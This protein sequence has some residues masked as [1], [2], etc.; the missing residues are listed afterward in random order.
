MIG[1]LAPVL[2]GA[3]AAGLLR[4]AGPGSLTPSR[5]R[6]TVT[7]DTARHALAGRATIEIRNVSDGPLARLYLHLYA[8]GYSGGHTAFARDRRKVAFFENPEGAIPTGDRTGS[9]AVRSL[10]VDGQ[11][12]PHTVRGTV[13]EVTIPQPLAVGEAARVDV[14][15]EVR[16]PRFRDRLGYRGSNYVLSGWYPK[17]AV[18][19]AIG[20]D[21]AQYRGIGEFYSETADYEVSITVP[22]GFVVGATGQL[23]RAAEG[24][25]G[26]G[27]AGADGMTTSW[28][29]AEQ[30][31]DF[32]WVADPRYRV[33]QS[34]WNGVVLRYLHFSRDEKAAEAGL[35]TAA[36]ALAF[37]SARYAPYPY[38]T[39]TIVEAS[40]I[41]DGLGI[42]Y[43]QLV[44][45]SESLHRNLRT[46]NEH[47][48]VLVH[49]VA[50]QWWYALV[51][52]NERT[53]AWLDE[54]FAT[55]ATRKFMEAEHGH[56]LALFR[57]PRAL[58]F[59]PAPSQT[60]TARYFY[61][62]QA[63]L[64]F[65]RPVRRRAADYD[66][67]QSYLVATYY[68]GSFVLDMLEYLVGRETFDEIM[69]TYADR[70]ALRTARSEDFVGVAE[71]VSGR[72]LTRFFAQWLDG[73]EVCDYGLESVRQAGGKGV[74]ELRRHGGIIMPVEVRIALA[75][76]GEI[77]RVWDGEAKATLLEVE[78]GARIASVELDPE[79]RLL[80]VDRVNN[81]FPRRWRSS[82][83]PFAVAEDA[84]TITHLPYVWYDDEWQLGLLVLAGYPPRAVFPAGIK[85][86]SG[87]VATAGYGLR[88]GDPRFA[89]EY[90]RT[91]GVLGPRAFWDLG[92]GRR[93]GLERGNAGVQWYLGDYFY[94][95]PY[96]SLR[97]AVAHERWLDDSSALEDFDHPV[98]VGTLR[99]VRAGYTFNDLWSD[100]FPKAGGLVEL[101]VEGASPDLGS[102]WR[103]LRVHG[104]AELYRSV[105]PGTVALNVFHGA[106]WGDPPRQG[107]LLL[108]RDANFLASELRDV[109]GDRLSA[110]NLEFR[111]GTAGAL[112]V[113]G[114]LVA[115][116]AKY[117]GGG[118]AGGGDRYG[119]IALGVRW[120]ENAPFAL[121]IDVPFWS[122]GP[123]TDGGS[124][125]VS[126]VVVRA[127]RTF[128]RWTP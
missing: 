42:E 93:P 92:A 97:L 24:A 58:G 99:A 113:A 86:E 31:R 80:E 28:W 1:P 64:G 57:W 44:M 83:N 54:A 74:I 19:D 26:A 60:E 33:R 109:S 90:S 104:R 2:C 16:L 120:F 49:E 13:M 65:D 34:T 127:G 75:D 88:S 11:P 72:D 27:G 40:A 59:L 66:D 5:Y 76:G 35:R 14:A 36:E 43:P 25:E 112:P 52:N 15:F 85:R 30:V 95:T 17:L 111:V 115:N 62:N 94:R 124:F 21:T 63:A 125:D 37:F 7:L 126:R 18:L 23:V 81:R 9:I 71:A 67:L 102:T 6:I 121:Q 79:Q 119:E 108:R 82:F 48:L 73:T 107:Q 45:L 22:R 118:A 123:G 68:K 51:G 20:W 96:H 53:E 87:I 8:N 117:W 56:D 106:V 10:L 61:A 84:F 128:R 38:P 98:D 78:T 3:L 91:L 103:Y 29:R 116:V 77:R 69:R 47:A 122:T 105:G 70:F 50:H 89:V 114:A 100:F 55:H 4:P 12:A 32:A 39:F 101:G 110:A 46:S 41:A